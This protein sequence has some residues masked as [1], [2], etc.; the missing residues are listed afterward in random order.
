M[1]DEILEHKNQHDRDM[2]AR[3]VRV[4]PCS[5]VPVPVPIIPQNKPN[6][7]EQTKIRFR[8]GRL[9]PAPKRNPRP[10]AVRRNLGYDELNGTPE[11]ITRPHRL[12]NQP[13]RLLPNPRGNCAL[14]G[15]GKVE[16]LGGGE[17][18]R[19]PEGERGGWGGL[20]G[21]G[22]GRGG[23]GERGLWDWGRGRRRGRIEEKGTD[24]TGRDGGRGNDFFKGR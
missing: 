14:F 11:R 24:R 9:D 20:E 5:S 18:E 21:G 6:H 15:A 4:S 22:W 10:L 23:E 8:L 16:G 13:R 1:L 19:K 3:S 7:Y 17:G 12:Q 2:A